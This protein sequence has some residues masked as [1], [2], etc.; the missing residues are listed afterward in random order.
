M[1]PANAFIDMSFRIRA[2][3]SARDKKAV[4]DQIFSAAS[5]FLSELLAEAHF[6]LS[7]EMREI[8]P[9]L[10]WKK[11]AMHARLRG[12]GDATMQAAQEPSNV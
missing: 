7:L 3:R 9:E 4:G 11:N 1:L 12:G 6:A 5:T 10:S 8:D 2:G